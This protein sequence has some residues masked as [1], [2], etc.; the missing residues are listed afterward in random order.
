MDKPCCLQFICMHTYIATDAFSF[1]FVSF[2][3]SFDD[4]VMFLS[5]WWMAIYVI[6]ITKFVATKEIFLESNGHQWKKCTASCRRGATKLSPK[7][8]KETLWQKW[9]R[10]CGTFPSAG[11]IIAPDPLLDLKP[12][13]Y[14]SP[15]LN[16]SYSSLLSHRPTRQTPDG[17]IGQSA[18]SIKQCFDCHQPIILPPYRVRTD[19]F[20]VTQLRQMYTRYIG[21]GS[22]R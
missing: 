14:I 13:I 2:H 6:W 19:R 4:S 22:C 18:T 5:N 20:I 7:H 21:T 3:W 17:Q 1:Y 9:S 8:K 10:S 12:S 11:D 15:L 16:E